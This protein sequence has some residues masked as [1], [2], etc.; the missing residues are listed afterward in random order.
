[1]QALVPLKVA[2]IS[3]DAILGIARARPNVG[4]ALW[5]DT[6]VD[7]SVS[8]EWIANIGRRDARTRMAHMLCEF[9]V[10]LRL[11]GVA[12]QDDYQLPMTQEQVADATGMTSVHANRIIRGLEEDGLIQR[13][14]SRA[15]HIN[16]WR[17]LAAAGEFESAYLHLRDNEPALA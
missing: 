17:A 16:D 9:A 12:Q 7:G 15:I 10:R 3:R 5:Y 14:T 6:L 2:F 8:R 4:F 11:A 13:A 1:V